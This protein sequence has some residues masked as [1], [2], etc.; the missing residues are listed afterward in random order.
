MAYRN[1]SQLSNS[2]SLATAMVFADL[3][4]RYSMFS[5]CYWVDIYFGNSHHIN[6]PTVLWTQTTSSHLSSASP[7]SNH[8]DT[9]SPLPQHPLQKAPLLLFPSCMVQ[10]GRGLF[11]SASIRIL[12]KKFAALEYFCY[13]KYLHT[14]A[15]HHF[16]WSS[17]CISFKQVCAI[18]QIFK[19]AQGQTQ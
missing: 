16:I 15:S 17:G 9:A 14:Y 19:S 18:G 3:L 2:Q 11:F 8:T 6:V 10:T 5:L 1:R 4:L 13:I 12:G 7:A